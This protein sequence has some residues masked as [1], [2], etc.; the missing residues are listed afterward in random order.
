[1][2]QIILALVATLAIAPAA[3]AHSKAETT[4]PANESTVE[5]VEVIE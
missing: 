4:T 2:K 3:L 1:M 5:K